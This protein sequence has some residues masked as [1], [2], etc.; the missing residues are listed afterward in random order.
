MHEEIYARYFNLD[1]ETGALNLQDR[2][3]QNNSGTFWRIRRVVPHR[4]YHKTYV[5]ENRMNGTFN[6]SFL[7]VNSNTGALRMSATHEADTTNWLIR[8]AGKFWGYDAYVIQHLTYT[9]GGFDMMFLSVDPDTYQ[10]VLRRK[11][12]DTS[13]WF[14]KA[15]DDLPTNILGGQGIGAWTRGED[16]APW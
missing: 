9:R 12:N 13:Y 11:L 10:P 2:S 1:G 4:G 6:G 5:L 15:A 7:D 14:I 3:N 8:Y 16:F